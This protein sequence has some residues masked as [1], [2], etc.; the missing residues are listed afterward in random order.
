MCIKFEEIALLAM[1]QNPRTFYA[2]MVFL[3]TIAGRTK[4]AVHK[5]D[6]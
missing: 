3:V 6:V 2:Y 1:K 5:R 4:F